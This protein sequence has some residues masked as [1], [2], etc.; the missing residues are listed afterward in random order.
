MKIYFH[1]NPIFFLLQKHTHT[2]NCKINNNKNKH[3]IVLFL[4]CFF[5][6]KRYVFELNKIVNNN[7]IMFFF[8]FL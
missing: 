1:V 3:D 5:V 4:F 6:P 7:K 8:I 2:E